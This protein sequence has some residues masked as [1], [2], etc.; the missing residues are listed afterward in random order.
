MRADCP[1]PHNKLHADPANNTL[2]IILA[3]SSPA[4]SISQDRT[5][6]QTALS[7][8]NILSRQILLLQNRTF[9]A[10][11]RMVVECTTTPPH[12]RAG[13]ARVRPQLQA[14]SLKKLPISI[15]KSRLSNCRM[16]RFSC[17]CGSLCISLFSMGEDL[18]ILHLKGFL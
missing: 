13:T 8:I 1:Q 15:R 17:P 12:S 10:P 18:S 7:P 5:S 11:L 3:I 16:G 4:F 14:A 2:L 9:F 6:V